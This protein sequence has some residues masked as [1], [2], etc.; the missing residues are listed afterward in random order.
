MALE[1]VYTPMAPPSTIYKNDPRAV[2]SSAEQIIYDELFAHF[3]AENPLYTL[4]DVENGELQEREKFWLSREC[5][6]RYV[7]L[8]VVQKLSLC[9]LLICRFLR[10]SKWKK[11]IAI[12]RLEN[13]LKWRREYG[14]YGDVV[15]AEH[16]E[17]EVRVSITADIESH[18]RIQ[19]K[20]G[21]EIVFG[22]DTKGRPGTYMIPS[23]QN[24]DGPE[25]QIQ[26]VFWMVERCIEL[27]EPGVEY[28]PPSQFAFPYLI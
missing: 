23:R 19:A 27:M 24:T 22:Y 17:P 21:K 3:T 18:T 10:A 8:R 15:N 16:V 1:K 28:V 13:T 25:R 12:S 9:Q 5:I 26:F 7:E 14:I 11:E 4:P 20:T 2:L 6:L